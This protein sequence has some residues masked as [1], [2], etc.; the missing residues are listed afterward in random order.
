L[1]S[2]FAAALPAAFF[3]AT[4]GIFGGILLAAGLLGEIGSGAVGERDWRV[5]AERGCGRLEEPWEEGNETS[6]RRKS[7]ERKVYPRVDDNGGPPLEAAPFVP[8]GAPEASL[9]RGDG[10]GAP[11]IVLCHAGPKKGFGACN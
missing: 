9:C 1:P 10:L 8:F 7:G 3:A 4:L 11:D 2:C 6:G 5:E